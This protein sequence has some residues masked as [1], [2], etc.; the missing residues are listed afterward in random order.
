[1]AKQH[2]PTL[3]LQIA[4][5]LK[6]LREMRN[7]SQEAVLLDTGIHIGRIE[8][9]KLDVT[10]STVKRLCEYFEISLTDFFENA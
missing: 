9:G 6:A 5:R 2:D 1:M 4:K 3:L 10:V 8:T 7:L